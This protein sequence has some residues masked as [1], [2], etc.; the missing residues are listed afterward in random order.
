MF[1]QK[2]LFIL[3]SF[4]TVFGQTTLSKVQPAKIEGVVVLEQSGK[5]VR[6]I[7]VYIVEGEEEDVTNNKGEF[8]IQTWHRFPLTLTA[9]SS[10]YEPVNIVVKDASKKLLIKLKPKQ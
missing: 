4:G 8:K 10:N 9:R 1:I 5:P 2:I 6:D 7:H 3:F